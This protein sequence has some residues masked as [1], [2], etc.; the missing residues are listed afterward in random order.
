MTGR[1]EGEREK[2][3]GTDSFQPFTEGEGGKGNAKGKGTDP[4]HHQTSSKG[5][6]RCSEKE[7]RNHTRIMMKG[8]TKMKG[9]KGR[10]GDRPF[11]L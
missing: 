2:G 10:K 1:G 6:K 11:L 9:G 3:K 4:L 5:W 7:K 8:T